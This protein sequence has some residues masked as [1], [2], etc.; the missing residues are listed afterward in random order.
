MYKETWIAALFSVLEMEV[1]KVGKNLE[2]S[3]FLLFS[4]F[5]TILSFLCF[6]MK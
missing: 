5:L 1:L 6:D 3:Q 2:I 4:R